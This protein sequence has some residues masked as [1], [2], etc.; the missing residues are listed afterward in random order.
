MMMKLPYT[1]SGSKVSII[2]L[3]KITVDV[4]NDDFNALPVDQTALSRQFAFFSCYPANGRWRSGFCR[5]WL[6]RCQR[7]YRVY[8]G[9]EITHRIPNMISKKSLKK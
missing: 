1:R 7:P 6:S 3:T 2:N 9:S 5:S 8:V 4:V